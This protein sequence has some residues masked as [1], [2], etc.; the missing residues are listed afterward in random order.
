MKKLF[1][2]L[3]VLFICSSFLGFAAKSTMHKHPAP[4]FMSNTV[5]S[6]LQSL[7]GDW[8]GKGTMWDMKTQTNMPWMEQ[9]SSKPTL[10]NKFLHMDSTS[11]TSSFQ[12]KGFMTY[13][14][15][16]GEYTLHWFDTDGFD[17]KFEGKKSGNTIV[18][19]NMHKHKPV[20]R[21]TMTLDNPNQYRLNLQMMHPGK[22]PMTLLDAVYTRNGTAQTTT[23][24]TKY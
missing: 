16:E 2:S 19:D 22:A 21:L 8:T 5:D 15:Q 10:G 14:S 4:E 9:V 24:Q 23:T 12:G 1:L 7:A 13:N 20:M 11:T 6:V 18:M 3:A 17:G